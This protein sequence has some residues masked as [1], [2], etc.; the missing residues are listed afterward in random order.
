MGSNLYFL[1]GMADQDQDAYINDLAKYGAKVVRVWV[2]QQSAGHCEKGSN[3]KNS[4][5]QLETTLGKYNDQTLDA[6][7]NVVNKL[8]QKGIKAIISPHDANSLLGDYRKDVYFD[9]FGKGSFYSSQDA[10]DAYDKRIEHILNYTGKYSRKQWK[11]WSEGIMAFDLQNEPMSPD[12]SVCKNNDSK[13]WLCGRAK[14]FR[15]VLG[16]ESNIKI[17]TGGIGGDISHDCTFIKAATQCKEID[18]IAVHRY[19]GSEG[20]NPGQWSNSAKSWISQSGGKLVFIEEWGVN[21]K[22]NN[23]K[24]ELPAQ[25]NDINKAGIPNLYW[26]FLPKNQC[27]YDPKKDSGDNFGIFVESDTDIAAVMKGASSANAAQDWSKVLG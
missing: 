5:P 16:A 2:N 27:G 8:A 15:S 11:S 17:A 1:P 3:L 19:G 23:P 4:V 9:K 21:V 13:G 6:V 14:K 22:S 25:A 18:L 12:P 24:T 10:F 20:S 7:D 26:Q